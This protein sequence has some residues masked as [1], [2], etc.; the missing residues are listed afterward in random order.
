MSAFLWSSVRV[1]VLLVSIYSFRVIVYR[2]W[3]GISWTRIHVFHH[4][5]AFSRFIF[6][7][8]VLSKSIWLSSFGPSSSP[9]NSFVMLRIHSAFLLWSLSSHILL[10]FF[11]FFW[12]PLGLVIGAFSC[13][14]P[15]LL[16]EFSFVVLYVLFRL[17]CFI[18]SRCLFILLSFASTC[19][20]ISSSSIFIFCIALSFLSLYFPA[21]FLCFIILACFRRFFLHFHSK[22]PST[23]FLFFSWFLRYYLPTPPLGQDMTQGQF[24]S[25]V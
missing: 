10:I 16:I 13:Y 21:F 25:G 4:G 24:L 20:L 7:C 5:L 15:N 8:A 14:L 12:F 6:Y 1:R 19:C 9:A 11:F 18:L 17:Y 3:R 23:F 2:E 22:F